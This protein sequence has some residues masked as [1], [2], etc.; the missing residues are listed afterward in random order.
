MNSRRNWIKGFNRNGVS[1]LSSLESLEAGK[2]ILKNTMENS[3][4][5]GEERPGTVGTQHWGKKKLNLKEF[6]SDK[7][8]YLDK[9]GNAGRSYRRIPLCFIPGSVRGRVWSDP[10]I[11]KTTE[12]RPLCHGQGLPMSGVGFLVWNGRE[13]VK[14]WDKTP[15]KNIGKLNLGSFPMVWEIEALVESV[16]ESEPGEFSGDPKL[17]RF[18]KCRKC[19]KCKILKYF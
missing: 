1:G 19:K 8:E 4:K 5:M 18:L 15:Q 2:R 9:F 13:R 16:E 7:I 17:K 10:K 3:P 11:S 12:F 6:W 14:S